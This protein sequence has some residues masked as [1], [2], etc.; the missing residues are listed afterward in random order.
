[1]KSLKDVAAELGVTPK[2]VRGEIECGALAAHRIGKKGV[3]RVPDEAIAEYKARTLVVPAPTVQR[4]PRRSPPPRSGEV[5]H[6]QAL[7][8]EARDA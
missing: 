3:Y 8:A 5:R 7:H 2:V 1:M 4:P 6:L